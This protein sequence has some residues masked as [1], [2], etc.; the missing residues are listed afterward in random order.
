MENSEQFIER[1]VREWGRRYD[2]RERKRGRD[3]VMR[4]PFHK[5]EK[6]SLS[7]H[8]R[9]GKWHCF[10]CGIGSRSFKHLVLKFAQTFA[11][12]S[13]ENFDYSDVGDVVT[14]S[15]FKLSK[16]YKSKYKPVKLFKLDGVGQGYFISRGFN[17]AQIRVL[18]REFDITQ[19]ILEGT[20]YVRFGIYDWDG[21]FIGWQ[22]RSIEG[23]KQYHNKSGFDAEKYFFGEWKITKKQ[24]LHLV[25][26]IFDYFK[27]WLA[28]FNV[29]A[30]LNYKKASLKLAR[31]YERYNGEVAF[32]F[33]EGVLGSNER[34]NVEKWIYYAGVFNIKNR[35]IELP[36]GS[37]DPGAM[38]I[39]ALRNHVERCLNA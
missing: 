13:V 29:M 6:P 4:C 18:E 27:M 15:P 38:E 28:G 22:R 5:D 25:E 24:P 7:V 35:Y 21:N 23:E 16:G 31:L 11:G 17:E 14:V 2:L 30:I 19:L 1:K 20:R 12:E 3:W 39:L 34:T 9:D 10:G 26:G 37:K 36:V 8:I 32:L 33:D